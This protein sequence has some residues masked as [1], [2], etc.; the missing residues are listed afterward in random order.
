VLIIS[1][2][3]VILTILVAFRNAGDVLM[4]LIPPAWGL[5][6]VLAWMSVFHERL[7][8]ANMIA[9]PV[10]LGICVDYGIFMVGLART[11]RRAGL[12][13]EPL[14]RR[15]ATSA[16]TV[17][18]TSATTIIGFGTLVTSSTPAIQSMG[19][20]VALGVGGCVIAT[21]FLLVP[22]LYILHRSQPREGRQE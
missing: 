15:M 22:L 16:H 3:A 18:M 1:A 9:F 8:M 10:L 6:V 2:A 12:G 11:C 20:L 21:L 17:L 13:T 5:L 14:I 4:A 19:R 7:N